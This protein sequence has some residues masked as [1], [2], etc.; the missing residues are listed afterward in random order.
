VARITSAFATELVASGV[1]QE[2]LTDFQ[3]PPMRVYA[4]FPGRR[5]MP[6]KVKVFMDALHRRIEQSARGDLRGTSTNEP[7]PWP[8][9]SL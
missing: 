3:I 9:A 8:P 4:V 1:L 2:V 7:A 6:A 5:L